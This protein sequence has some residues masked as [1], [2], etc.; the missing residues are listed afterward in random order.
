MSAGAMAAGAE[1]LRMRLAVTGVVQG[2]G[3]RPF[4]YGLA[5]AGELTGFVGNNSEGVFIEVEGAAGA[6]STFQARLVSEL[7]PLAYIEGVQAEVMA[8]AGDDTF[9][10]VPSQALPAARTLISPD[11]ALCPDCRRELLDPQDRRYGYP[12]INCTHCG[13]RFTLIKD[14]PY[15]RPFTTMA[16]FPMCPACQAEYNDPLN[17]RFHA[18][19]NACPD[20]GPQVWLETPAGAAPS[21]HGTAALI[22]VQ[23]RLRQGQIVAIKGVGGFHLA[24]DARN[25][26]AVQ[27]L[28]EHK[29][30]QDKPFA[31]MA[32]D[33]EA[34]RAFAAVTPD[35]AAL[36][37][38]KES[39][40]V[41]LDKK[42]GGDLAPLVA[43]GQNTVGVMLPYSPLHLLLF[44]S[45]APDQPTATALVMTSG[46][47][48]GE[49]II[50]ANDEARRNLAGLADAFLLHDREIHSRCDD[51]VLRITEF[52][53][54][55]VLPLRRSRGYAP[56]PIKLPFA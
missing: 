27:R 2:V 34:V 56:F 25:N 31:V 24:C 55:A 39:P 8:P 38:S 16:E 29:G 42:V 19:P 41:L 11:I 43:P 37:T 18:Q 33:L 54:P 20:C 23:Q 40:I 6:I 49:P 26:E 17:R 4:V 52:A 51:S 53:E 5:R 44:H 28:R 13:P 35:E 50:C 10:I 36:L 22:E 45:L 21:T 1:R 14:I 3:F 32:R 9:R 46:N 47:D 30:R 12:F 48:N 15:D 7:P